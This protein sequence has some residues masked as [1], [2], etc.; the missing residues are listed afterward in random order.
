MQHSR[1]LLLTQ[2]LWQQCAA[3]VRSATG[4][5]GLVLADTAADT[6]TVGRPSIIC[7][8]WLS[9]SKTGAG[10]AAAGPAL[11]T[12]A[13]DTVPDTGHASSA[14]A[15]GSGCRSAWAA[16]AAGPILALTAAAAGQPTWQ[17]TCAAAAVASC[18]S[19]PRLAALKGL[20]RPGVQSWEQHCRAQQEGQL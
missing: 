9:L 19:L 18:R 20:M 6:D 8:C 2:N 14:A 4:G 12:A 15:A 17:H 7:C 11:A 3:G 16:A 13:A 1:L 10:T 5:N